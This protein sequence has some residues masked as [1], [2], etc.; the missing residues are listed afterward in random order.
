MQF[1]GGL[2]ETPCGAG[3]TV[4]A[5]TVIRAWLPIILRKLRVNSMLDAPC[6]DFNWLAHTDLSGIHYF[7]VDNNKDHVRLA[8]EKQSAPGFEPK[9]KT[10][11]CI[12]I[13]RHVLPMHV[14][15]ILCRDFMQHLPNARVIKLLDNFRATKADWLIATSHDILY[16][17]DIHK[18]GDFRPLNLCR[19]PFG[20]PIPD[21]SLND[22]GRMLALWSL[23]GRSV[24]ENGSTA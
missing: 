20:F 23:S 11:V 7:G 18:D 15:L 19:P 14:D 24:D 21:Y 4:K 22:C 12:D 10:V 6:G 2:P 8:K 9:Y 16:N 1:T 3:S 5:T 13:V 17:T